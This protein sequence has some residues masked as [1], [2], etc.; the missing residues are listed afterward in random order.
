MFNLNSVASLQLFQANSGGGC[1][2]LCA[3]VLSHVEVLA[4]YCFHYYLGSHRKDIT[5]FCEIQVHM[6]TEIMWVEAPLKAYRLG[7]TQ[8]CLMAQEI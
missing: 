6:L 5:K 2:C 4:L 8:W 3:F 7:T 1:V